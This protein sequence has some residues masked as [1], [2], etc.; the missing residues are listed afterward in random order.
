MFRDVNTDKISE[1]AGYEV[2]I[3]VK[4]PQKDALLP[5]SFVALPVILLAVIAVVWVRV[6]VKQR[7]N[8][9]E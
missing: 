5:M 7:R 9:V 8:C 4:E 2:R 6:K 3:E 1:T